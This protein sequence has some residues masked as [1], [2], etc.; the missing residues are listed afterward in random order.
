MLLI[1]WLCT[2]QKHYH[3][4]PWH[5]ERWCW[6]GI[7]F[8]P[9]N[10]LTHRNSLFIINIK[11]HSFPSSLQLKFPYISSLFSLLSSLFSLLSFTV[12]SLPPHSPLFLSNNNN[13]YYCYYCYYYYCGYLAKSPEINISL[14]TYF[15]S[16]LHRFFSS[17]FFLFHFSL[18]K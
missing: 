11:I 8:N 15:L 10:L 5:K 6:G 1:V 17:P 18:G 2:F 14:F 7:L 13:N 9:F 16:F 3:M 4:D 12:S